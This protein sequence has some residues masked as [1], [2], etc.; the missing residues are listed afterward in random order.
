MKAKLFRVFM[1]SCMTLIGSMSVFGQETEGRMPPPEPQRPSA[2]QLTDEVRN[3]I[4]LDSKE[5][6][7]VHSAYE[8]YSKSV[9]GEDNSNLSQPMRPEGRPGGGPGGMGGP[10]GP[11]G[12][13]GGP[14]G[15][16]G[17]KGGPG[18]MGGPGGGMPPHSTLPDNK[19]KTIDVE[20]FEKTKTKA[21]EK[22]CKTMK[23]IF[24]KNPGKYD[25]WL[26]LRNRQLENMFRPQPPHRDHEDIK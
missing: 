12:G 2:Y 22:L 7:K 23:K 5:F 3:A 14:G 24:K 19:P 6:E 8:K 21:E 26:S 18:G 4:G 17:G 9:F 25:S 16:G 15:P 13:K 1:L 20:K 11:G 10:G